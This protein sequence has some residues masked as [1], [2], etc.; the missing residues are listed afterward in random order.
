MRRNNIIFSDMLF[1]IC[2]EIH[3]WVS[4][5]KELKPYILVRFIWILL[6]NKNVLQLVKKN[7]LQIMY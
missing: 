6:N 2:G 4:P 7:V 3:K 5:N 1:L